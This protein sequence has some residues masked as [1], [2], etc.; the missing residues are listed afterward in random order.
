MRNGAAMRFTIAQVKGRRNADAEPQAAQIGVAMDSARA[1][2]YL[3][4]DASACL[5]GVALP[6]RARMYFARPS[7]DGAENGI[8]Y[9]SA[10][11]HISLCAM[12]GR[13]EESPDV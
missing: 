4:R 6:I 5:T 9:V 12:T 7:C 13:A 10:N 11:R 1:A 8:G 3:A 2:L